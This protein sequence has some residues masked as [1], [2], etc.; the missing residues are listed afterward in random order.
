MLIYMPKTT[1]SMNHITDR[2]ERL[3]HRRT[4]MIREGR[5]LSAINRRISDCEREYCEYLSEDTSA[6]GGPAGAVTGSSV[7]SYGVAT[8]GMGAVVSPQP[9]TLAGA[10]T[11]SAWSSGGGTVGSGD[12]G[13]PFPGPGGKRMYQKAEMGRSHGAMTGKKSR[14]KKMNIK[15]LRDALSRRQDYTKGSERPVNRGSS[16]T[17]PSAPS[18]VMSWQ[19]FQ[20]SDIN[21]VKKVK[22]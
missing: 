1:T 18:R 4:V 16:A 22:Y 10:T 19:D 8:S 11:G 5:D 13:F 14:Q 12:I 20:K 21:R 3:I 17:A 6:T 9:S 15:Q 7:G 2:M